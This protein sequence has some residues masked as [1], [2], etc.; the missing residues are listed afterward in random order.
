MKEKKKKKE[1]RLPQIVY[2]MKGIKERKSPTRN[3]IMNEFKEC[4][5]REIV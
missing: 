1:C 4:H 5:L 2:R 3:C